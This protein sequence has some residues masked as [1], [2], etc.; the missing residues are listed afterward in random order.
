MLAAAL[1][2]ALAGRSLVA[3]VIA[4]WVGM[5]FYRRSKG[6]RPKRQPEWEGDHRCVAE[7]PHPPTIAPVH[8]RA[9]ANAANAYPRKIKPQIKAKRKPKRAHYRWDDEVMSAWQWVNH[10]AEALG[11]D[12]NRVALAGY[13][14]GG[15][16]AALLAARLLAV[17]GERDADV[18][19]YSWQ[20]PSNV[21]LFCGLYDL[22]LA[23]RGPRLYKLGNFGEACRKFINTVI[24]DTLRLSDDTERAAAS[25]VL[26]LQKLI[27]SGDGQSARSGITKSTCLCIC[28]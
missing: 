9:H 5:L 24:H 11:G 28:Q 8:T 15:H 18:V 22:T 25:P 26:N 3:T 13:S 6:L 27:A 16:L 23:S 14:S 12:P 21:F 2:A 10:N 20:R 19:E 1:A 17:A 7:P 4:G